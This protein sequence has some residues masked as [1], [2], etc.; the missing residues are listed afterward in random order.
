MHQELQFPGRVSGTDLRNPDFAALAHAYGAFGE[1]VEQT[2]AFPD[3]F[4]RALG[5]GVPAVVHLVTDPDVLT[6]R[7][8]LGEMD[9]AVV[10]SS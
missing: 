5:A 3:A 2:A 10:R 9:A 4:E 7:R 6:P 1:R 8:T